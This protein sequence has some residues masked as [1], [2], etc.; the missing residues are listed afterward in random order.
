MMI[1]IPS[2]G[3]WNGKQS[4][5]FQGKVRR[6]YKGGQGEPKSMEVAQARNAKKGI[7][8]IHVDGRTR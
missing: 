5:P 8:V 1:E 6:G 7:G 2:G 3:W 4:A